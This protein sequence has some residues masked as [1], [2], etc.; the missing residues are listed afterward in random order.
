MADP[1]S[2]SIMTIATGCE[3]ARGGKGGARS[4]RRGARAR[5]LVHVASAAC[6][7][8]G[9]RERTQTCGDA[10]ARERAQ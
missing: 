8:A 3:R 1:I 5:L 9:A 7:D 6:A 2:S 10:G 4:P